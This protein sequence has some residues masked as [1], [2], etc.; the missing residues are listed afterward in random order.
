MTKVA[1]FIKQTKD[2]E[3]KIHFETRIMQTKLFSRFDEAA[4]FCCF[5]AQVGRRLLYNSLNQ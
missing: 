2:K 1:F 4:D 5:S 3:I